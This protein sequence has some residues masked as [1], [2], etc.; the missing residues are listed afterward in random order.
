MNCWLSIKPGCKGQ[1]SPH[2][3]RFSCRFHCGLPPLTQ[4]LSLRDWEK[5]WTP[6]T[7]VQHP[8]HSARSV[9]LW[10]SALS[11]MSKTCRCHISIKCESLRNLTKKWMTV[12][13]PLWNPL[14]NWANDW[15]SEVNLPFT[16]CVP[17]TVCIF[18]HMFRLIINI[19]ITVLTTHRVSV[20]LT[21]YGYIWYL[22]G[23]P[24]HST[25]YRYR[26]DGCI[27]GPGGFHCSTSV[28]LQVCCCQS[29][30]MEHPDKCFPS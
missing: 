27:L 23:D 5:P 26:G 24:Q 28:W 18:L 14:E 13:S 4:N 8:D 11:N 16:S 1:T 2:K 6:C 22:F 19:W 10:T 29:R 20:D 30:K 17:M 9:F 12:K 7:I 15:R 21:N 3:G 25:L